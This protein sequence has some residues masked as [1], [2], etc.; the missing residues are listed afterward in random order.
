MDLSLVTAIVSCRAIFGA[1]Q[2]EASFSAQPTQS[3]SNIQVWPPDRERPCCWPGTCQKVLIWLHSKLDL[4]LLSVR[5]E[6]GHC[7]VAPLEPMGVKKHTS[8]PWT[9]HPRM[10]KLDSTQKTTGV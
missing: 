9:Q 4:A 2:G 6:L 10:K 5:P 7:D 3:L 1:T 8:T